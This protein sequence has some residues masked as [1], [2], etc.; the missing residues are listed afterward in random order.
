MVFDR[1]TKEKSTLAVWIKTLKTAP[2]TMINNNLERQTVYT[3]NYM[4]SCSRRINEIRNYLKESETRFKSTWSYRILIEEKYCINANKGIQQGTRKLVDATK[5]N[6]KSMANLLSSR[7]FDRLSVETSK[8]RVSENTIKTVAMN[9]IKAQS[10][11]LS[12]R[13]NRFKIERFRQ[14]IER[15]QNLLQNQL[16]AVKASD[17]ITSLKR[18][19]S[20]VYKKDNQLV[21]SVKAVSHGELLKTK[22]QDGLI[23]S[24][25]KQTEEN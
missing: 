9:E 1:L 3:K 16:T 7:V 18:G 8:L 13:K 5:A 20:L 4:S 10:R 22:V 23:T 6:L 15:Q 17:P 19:F 25:V 2:V 12:G 21:K 24:T 11:D 14:I